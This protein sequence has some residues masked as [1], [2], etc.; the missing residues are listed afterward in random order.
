[1]KIQG[2]EHI[3]QYLYKKLS[4]TAMFCDRISFIFQ[5][6]HAGSGLEGGFKNTTGVWKTSWGHFST[7]FLVRDD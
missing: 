2:T 4:L 3:K 1:M 7:G 6:I 5:K